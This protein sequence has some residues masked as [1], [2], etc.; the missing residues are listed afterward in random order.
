M[1][2]IDVRVQAAALIAQLEE[3]NNNREA[4]RRICAEVVRQL[5]RLRDHKATVEVSVTE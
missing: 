3:T 2:R 1:K 4:I 5:G